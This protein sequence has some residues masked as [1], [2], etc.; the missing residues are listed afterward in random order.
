M[1]A[2]EMTAMSV[3]PPPMSTIMLPEG[4]VIGMP[5]PIAA[6][7][8]SSTRCTSLALARYAL[9]LTARFSTCVISDGTPMTMRGR[10]Q[11]LRL[12][13]FLMKYVS[14]FSVTSKSAMTPSFIGLIA[15]M[16][17][18][19]RPSISLASLPTASTRPLIL[20]IAT[21]DG[22]LTTIPFTRAGPD[23]RRGFDQRLAAGEVTVPVVD[24]LEAVQVEKQERKRAAASRGALR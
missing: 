3:V 7:I 11:T 12:C 13:A 18:G 16:L 4:S 6:A 20:L 19:V 17:P 21:I 9:S 22:S 14:I 2:R 8:A 5:A 23:D 15:T 1:P 10:T 24:H